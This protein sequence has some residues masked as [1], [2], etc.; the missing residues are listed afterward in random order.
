MI[1]LLTILQRPGE[2][3]RRWLVVTFNSFIFENFDQL[4]S[5]A[6]NK[7]VGEYSIKGLLTVGYQIH[8]IN[9][10]NF[11]IWKTMKTKLMQ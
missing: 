10:I 9:Y 2:I 7:R 3:I 8:I 4:L 1:F 6:T 11:I 5:M